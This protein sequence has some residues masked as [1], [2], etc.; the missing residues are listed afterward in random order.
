MNMNHVVINWTTHQK[1][2]Q[3]LIQKLPIITHSFTLQTA[4]KVPTHSTNPLTTIQPVHSILTMTN[5][6]LGGCLHTFNWPWSL[7]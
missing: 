6:Q 1:D 7:K 5:F 3:I 4:R 2:T